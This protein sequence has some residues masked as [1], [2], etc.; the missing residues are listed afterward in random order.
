MHDIR[1]FYYVQVFVYDMWAR[2]T[3]IYWGAHSELYMADNKGSLYG[4]LQGYT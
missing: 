3:G 4:T 1:C 2:Y